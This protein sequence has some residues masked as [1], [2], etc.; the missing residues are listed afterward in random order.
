MASTAGKLIL[1][2]IIGVL[3]AAFIGFG[4]AY[5]YY[6]TGNDADDPKGFDSIRGLNNAEDMVQIGDTKWIL[7]GNLG[8]KNWESGGL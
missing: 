7:T 3:L 4:S 6:S 1:Y 2:I 8:D 5:S